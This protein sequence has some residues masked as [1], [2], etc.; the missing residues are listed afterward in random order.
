MDPDIRF[1]LEE[2]I[3]APSGENCQPWRFVVRGMD[4]ELW[5]RPERDQ[6][7]YGWGQRASYMAN[8]AALENL[9]LAAGSRGLEA[10]IE[11]FPE[12]EL[13]ARVRLSRGQVPTDPL[14]SEIAKRVSN[15][16]PYKT[17]P[18]TVSQMD[19]LQKAARDGV[20]ISVRTDTPS[21][22]AIAEVGATNEK[23]MLGNR[24][25]HGFF[26]SHLNWDKREDDE[27]KIGFYIKTL[28]LPPPAQAAFRI[29]RHWS[30]ARLLKTIGFPSAVFQQN[31]AMYAA[32]GAVGALCTRGME[33]LDFVLAGRSLERLW[34]TAT[35]LG[36]SFQ[37]LAGIPYLYLEATRGSRG[38][39]D[40]RETEAICAAYERAVSVFGTGERPLVFL[41]R[42]G[43][44]DPPSARSSR[45]SFDESVEIVQ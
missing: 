29:I 23:L 3:R 36:L 39:F 32:A 11:Y 13:V 21:I 20:D 10:H 14:A 27:K 12:K 44:S 41:F 35:R 9:V 22:R 38:M 2:A 8:G 37:P 19:A 33:P 25:L 4:V 40:T 1:A 26:F 16:K 31:A 18:L 34:L 17:S 7:P 28:E 5:N 42:V 6:S 43:V 15:R 45:F 30:V 24:L